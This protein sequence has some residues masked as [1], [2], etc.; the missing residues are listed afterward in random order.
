MNIAKFKAFFADNWLF[1]VIG[2]ALL[3]GIF[4][5]G[6][7]CGDSRAASK[8]RKQL[9]ET[10]RKSAEHEAKAAEAIKNEAVLAERNKILKETNEKQAALLTEHGSKELT[11]AANNL[12]AI[13]KEKQA[14]LDAIAKTP[15]EAQACQLCRE[16]KRAGLRFTFCEGVCN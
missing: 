5:L 16:A 13:Q 8:Y 7:S 6:E 14:K 10:M 3:A 4:F 2:L 12:E 1:I 15:D 9:E 11:R